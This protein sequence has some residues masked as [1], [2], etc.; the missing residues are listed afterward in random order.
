MDDIDKLHEAMCGRGPLGMVLAGG[1][2]THPDGDENNKRIH[3][4][5]VELQRRGLATGR[6]MSPGHWTWT[7]IDRTSIS[8]DIAAQIEGC[9][10]EPR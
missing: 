7:P 4:A 6:E 1:I 8:R 5:C 3:A 2:W 10:V 9:N